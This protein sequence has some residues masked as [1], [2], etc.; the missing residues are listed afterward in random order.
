MNVENC[1]RTNNNRLAAYK[2]K[3]SKVDRSEKAAI[4]RKNQRHKLLDQRRPFM[5]VDGNKAQDQVMCEKKKNHDNVTE[6]ENIEASKFRRQQLLKWKEKKEQ[7]KKKQLRELSRKKPFVVPVALNYIRPKYVSEND[8]NKISQVNHNIFQSKMKSSTKENAD[9]P[10]RITRSKS[11]AI[12]SKATTSKVT[13]KTDQAMKKV[14]NKKPTAPTV[15]NLRN[16]K[17]VIPG[18]KPKEQDPSIKQPTKTHQPNKVPQLA[19]N[20]FTFQPLNLKLPDL[21]PFQP[22]SPNTAASFLDPSP[23][24]LASPTLLN[25]MTLPTAREIGISFSSDI[26]RN[27]SNDKMAASSQEDSTNNQSSQDTILTPQKALDFSACDG[28]NRFRRNVNAETQRLN[29]LCDHWNQVKSELNLDDEARLED[30]R[31]QIDSAVGQAQLLIN[32]KFKQFHQLIDKSLRTETPHK[33]FESDLEGFWEMVFIQVENLNNKFGALKIL[34]DCNWVDNTKQKTKTK[35]GKK[36]N[37]KKNKKTPTRIANSRN[38]LR[39][40]IAAQKQTKPCENVEEPISQGNDQSENNLDNNNINNENNE[41]RMVLRSVTKKIRFADELQSGRNLIISPTPSK[42]RR[43]YR[44]TPGSNSSRSFSITQETSESMEENQDGS[45]TDSPS[46]V[47]SILKKTP[48]NKSTELLTKD[49]TAIPLESLAVTL[50]TDEKDDIDQTT[51]AINDISDGLPEDYFQPAKAENTDSL[52]PQL[53]DLSNGIVLPFDTI[54]PTQM[55]NNLEESSDGLLFNAFG[56]I[57]NGSSKRNSYYKQI[58]VDLLQFSPAVTPR[59]STTPRKS[60]WHRSS[61]KNKV[62]GSLVKRYA[63]ITPKKE[64]KV[65]LGTDIIFTPVIRSKRNEK[66][67]RRSVSQ[68]VVEK[69]HELPEDMDFGIQSNKHLIDLN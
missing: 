48:A 21:Q 22:L 66:S 36:G 32:K 64:M 55:D 67:G 45:L 56:G 38:K 17:I 62:E 13:T 26:T 39:E 4:D 59:K 9:K 52:S 12:A 41:N 16:R 63:S 23:A 40:F 15:K 42:R 44:K 50:F 34:Q 68:I 19:P 8:G 54:K 46:I 69:L 31:G 53:I 35:K 47:R 57:M 49:E 51:D 27:G 18:S 6:I 7:E 60:P 2:S 5:R 24:L 14:A 20:N 10:R 11:K 1:P 33:A 3:A 29:D 43:S 30:I 28:E 58:D 37:T 25:K 65:E 61:S